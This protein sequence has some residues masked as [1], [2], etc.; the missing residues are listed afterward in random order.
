MEN[1]GFILGKTYIYWSSVV[2]A[3]A[4]AA[5]ICMFLGLRLASG[6]KMTGTFILIPFG[7]LLS[8]VLGRFVHWYCNPD[9]YASFV[10]AMGDYSSGNYALMGVFAGCAITACVLWVLGLDK[11][12][13]GTFDCMAIA[14]TLGMSVGR[15]NHLFNSFDRGVV[16]QGIRSLPLVYPVENAVSGDL[17]YRL[18]TF[19]LQAIV[20]AVLFVVLMVFYFTKGRANRGDT[21][22]LFL[23]CYG[24]SQILLDSTR[25][26][27]LFMRSNGF[28]SLVQIFGAAFVVLSIVLFSVRMVRNRGWRWWYI[29]LWVAVVGLLTCAGIMEYQ[30]QRRGS[31]A[32]KFYSVMAAS[33]CGVAGLGVTLWALAAKVKKGKF[34]R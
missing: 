1:V 33:L 12:I 32:V 19:M 24:A 28:I 15:L 18:A 10:G 9:S 5:A 4:A 11:D 34:E 22:L 29:L 21:C 25:Y 30:V 17:E 2:L 31:E 26:D 16:V 13:A 7:V 8:M 6:E 23:L 14:G 3:V 20:A 27:S